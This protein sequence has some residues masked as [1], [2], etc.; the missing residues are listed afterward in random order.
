MATTSDKHEVSK[1]TYLTYVV[2][3]MH[4]AAGGCTSQFVSFLIM[5]LA[6]MRYVTLIYLSCDLPQT[7]AYW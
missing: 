2:A 5:A 1:P 4:T 6:I 7:A 3:V